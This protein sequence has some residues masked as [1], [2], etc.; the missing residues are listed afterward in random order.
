MKTEWIESDISKYK[1]IKKGHTNTS[2]YLKT[3]KQDYFYQ[4]FE[5]DKYN[6][7]INYDILKSFAFVPH[8]FYSSKKELITEYIKDEGIKIN[9]DSLEHMAKILNEIHNSNKKFPKCNINKRIN[10]YFAQVKK[11][12]ELPK[13]LLPL[14]RVVLKL[15]KTLDKNVPSHNDPW[16]DNFILNKKKFY[17]SDWEYATMNNKHF[18]LAYIITASYFTTYQEKIFLEY[19]GEYDQQELNICKIIVFYITLLWIFKQK[20]IPFPYKPL[21]KEMT[22]LI[23]QIDN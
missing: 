10:N 12:K 4:I 6:H 22:T 19:Y 13:E 1:Q 3:K 15:F 18:D 21:L 17:L 7:K 20:S 16:M 11:K 5:Y 23:K 8:T 14:K 9:D 2:Y